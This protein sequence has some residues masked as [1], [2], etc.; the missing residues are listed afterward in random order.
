MVLLYAVLT[1]SAARYSLSISVKIT[2]LTENLE[3]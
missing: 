1:C 2:S 3:L